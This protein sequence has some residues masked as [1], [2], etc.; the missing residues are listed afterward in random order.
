MYKP[1]HIK[2]KSSSSLPWDF[3]ITRILFGLILSTQVFSSEAPVRLARISGTITH[4]GGEAIPFAS[5]HSKSTG[6]WTLSD[7]YGFFRLSPIRTDGD[8]LI[9]ERVG[10][11]PQMIITKA[12]QRSIKII[13]E[14]RVINLPGLSIQAS[15]YDRESEV[16]QMVERSKDMGNVDQR[17]TFTSISGLSIRSYGGPAGISTLSLDGGPSTQAK[18][19]VGG[20]DITNAQNG[21]TDISQLPLPLIESVRYIPANISQF[22]SGSVDGVLSLEPRQS[23]RGIM[24]S[25]GSFGHRSLDFSWD[26]QINNWQASLIVG[27]RH[28]DGNYPVVWE[29]ETIY[30]QNNSFDQQYLAFNASLVINEVLYLRMMNIFSEQKRGIAGQVWS[31]DIRS[32]RDDELQL[33]GSTLGWRQDHGNGSLQYMYR[34]SKDQYTNPNNNIDVSHNLSTSHLQL[35][36]NSQLFKQVKIDLQAGLRR[37]EIHSGNVADNI[38]ITIDADISLDLQ[39]T[40]WLKFYPAVSIEVV[41]GLYQEILWNFGW[42][43]ITK[44]DWLGLI[45]L[46]AGEQF[47]YPSFND[48]YW[49]PGGNTDLLAERS[50]LFTLQSRL[51]LEWVGDLNLQIQ[52][53]KSENL[54]QW[55]PQQMAFWR[56]ENVSKSDRMS[57][58]LIWQKEWPARMMSS[59]AHLSYHRTHNFSSNYHLNKPLLYSPQITAAYGLTW[60][61]HPLSIRLDGR[62]VSSRISFYNYPEDIILPATTL[63]SLS[64][65]RE[66]SL[67]GRSLVSVFAIDNIFNKQYETIKGYPE[68][69]RQFRLTFN[70]QL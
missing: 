10:Y 22:G 40:A 8:T 30:R 20:F 4:S 64:A 35:K 48:L 9:A 23:G 59:F 36:Q 29:D 18:I 70:F 52:Y 27:N 1:V 58:K 3:F 26:H 7:E 63:W 37:E 67:F 53:R 11:A 50:D 42:E 34:G 60:N 21:E 61:P 39:T 5:V 2:P 56:P 33:L 51:L 44:Q 68:P 43:L 19:L 41:P 32:A 28:D 13:M 14:V 45:S 66:I 49:Q 55:M 47:R 31:P 54:I 57:A 65:S 38:R 46:Q 16:F 62:F 69:G 17:Q 24:Y 15:P 12:Q 25:Q 6:A